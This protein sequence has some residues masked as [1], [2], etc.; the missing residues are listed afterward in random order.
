MNSLGSPVFCQA[1]LSELESGKKLDTTGFVLNKRLAQTLG[2]TV[3]YLVGMY[4]SEESER[5]PATAALGFGA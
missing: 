3:D 4:K 1:L 5:K 2:V